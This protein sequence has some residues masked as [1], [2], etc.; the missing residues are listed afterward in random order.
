MDKNNFNTFLVNSNI[1]VYMAFY[2]GAQKEKSKNNVQV[3]LLF[4][5]AINKL[6]NL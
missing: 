6:S 3:T 4:T 5:V 2:C 1:T